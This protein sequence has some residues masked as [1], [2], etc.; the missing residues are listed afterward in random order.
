MKSHIQNR[1]LRSAIAAMTIA[2]SAGAFAESLVQEIIDARQETQIWTTYALSP[3]LR[4]NDL[5]VSARNGTVI[6]TGNVEE[7][8]NKDLAGAIA[9][10]VGGVKHVDNQ[11]VIAADYVAPVPGVEH[12]YGGFVDDATTTAAIRSKLQW[13]KGTE[14]LSTSVSTHRGKVTLTGKA[15]TQAGKD[16]A[17]KLAMNTRGVYSVDN[18][19]VVERKLPASEEEN[20]SR[21]ASA[22][23]DSWITTKVRSTLMY[24]SNVNAKDIKI[25]TDKGVVTLSGKVSSGVERALAIELAENIRGVKSV[26]YSDLAI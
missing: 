16:I 22:V 6:L 18:Q 2:T 15:D 13:S 5:Q 25:N 4:A 12:P 24:S 1:M 10:G 7:D 19:L 9:M 8:V 26:V 23:A 20:A 14:G 3:Y 11:I 17:T 21:T